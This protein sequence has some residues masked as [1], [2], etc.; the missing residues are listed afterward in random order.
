MDGSYGAARGQEAPVRVPKTRVE[1]LNLLVPLTR[2]PFAT[3]PA[4]AAAFQPRDTLLLT[5]SLLPDTSG[6]VVWEQVF[7]DSLPAGH[8][9]RLKQ[10]VQEAGARIA[11]YRQAG[12]PG[13]YTLLCRDDLIPLVR[14]GDTYWAPQAYVLTEY[15]QIRTRPSRAFPTTDLATINILNRP[16][17][18]AQLLQEA[19][20]KWHNPHAQLY[21]IP[22]GN[23]LQTRTNKGYE[24][25]SN[26]SGWLSHPPLLHFGNGGFRYQP[27]I[28]L[29]SARYS[30][31]FDLAPYQVRQALGNDFFDVIAIDGKATR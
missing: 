14:R 25:W 9:Q 19:R 11:A 17:P 29:V 20:I 7:L 15:F 1:I 10:A 5:F 23:V 6:A 21:A 8:Y 12:S 30:F 24:F 18:T 2:R 22:A 26:P 4:I 3:T 31:Y 16:F 13:E 28:G 27:K